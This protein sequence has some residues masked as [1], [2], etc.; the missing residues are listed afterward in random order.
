MEGKGGMSG[1]RRLEVR[2]RGPGGSAGRVGGA[3]GTARPPTPS[4]SA[5]PRKPAWNIPLPPPLSARELLETVS[6]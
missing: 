6:V 1:E 2:G 5:R 4:E 3:G